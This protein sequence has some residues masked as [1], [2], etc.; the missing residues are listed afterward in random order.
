MTRATADRDD[1]LRS[2]EIDAFDTDRLTEHMRAEGRRQM[3]LEW[4]VTRWPGGGRTSTTNKAAQGPSATACFQP[5]LP[6]QRR[7]CGNV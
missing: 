1:L 5:P 2:T 7:K 3:L 4:M 6:G